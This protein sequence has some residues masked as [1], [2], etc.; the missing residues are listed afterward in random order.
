MFGSKSSK[1]IFY[2]AIAI[3]FYAY[4]SGLFIDVTRDAGKYATIS[5]EVFQNGNYINLTINGE[6]YDQ[7]PP[8][9]FWLGALGFSI[10][11]ISN[12]WFK[13]P[14]QLLVFAG[15]YWAFQLGK[16]LYNKRVGILTATIL[17]FSLI[18]SMYSMDIHTDTPFQ[19]FVILALWQLY[20]FI[21]T[22]KNK[23]WIIGFVAIGLSML[24]KGPLGAVVVA[25][26]VLGHILLKKDFWFL[27]DPRWYLGVVLAFVV[28][29][30]ALIGLWNQFGWEGIRFFFWENNVGRI[31]GSYVHATN[32][33]IFYVH[34]LM[35]LLLPW[36]LLFFISA[37]SEFRL[38]VKNRLRASEYF[39]FTG[40]WIF[41]VIINASSSQLPNYVF[42]IVPLMAVLIAKWIDIA[43]EGNWSLL[44]IMA[45][46]QTGVV[47]VLWILMGVLGFY[48]FPNTP[49][50]IVLLAFV[51]IVIIV[52]IYIKM[53]DVLA[54]L[55]LPSVISFVVLMV[56]LNVHVY[57]Y[58]FG[59]QAPPKA[60]RYFT[61]NASEG[62]RLY[63]Y[64]Y[65]Q[66]ELFF[67]SE[68]QAAQVYTEE[69]LGCVAGI[70]GNWVF[71]NPEGLA[72]LQRLVYEPDTII[73]YSHLSLNRGGRFIN[74]KTRDAVLQPMYL[75]KY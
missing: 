73:E 30:P 20:E 57:P 59:F 37:F 64:K 27:I 50:L 43:I 29:S 61:E 13:L 60:G 28:A 9:L 63:G 38:L 62:D 66:Y 8:L 39:T 69:E 5:K 72:D 67:Y 1:I 71:T 47:L 58:M 11:G 36:S 34:S 14:I 33:P 7:K 74:P 35:Y 49:A 21:K 70:K 25:F 12:F 24:C 16:S 41:F 45:Y 17:F 40:I 44:K 54:R 18:Y 46:T 48:L 31:T 23:H 19:A 55:I 6:R 52:Y 2:V 42:C 4:F 65:K 32:D 15:F 3:A 68:P 53:S 22:K 10:G 51:G 26:A 56:L 75:L